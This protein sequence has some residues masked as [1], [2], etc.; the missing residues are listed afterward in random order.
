MAIEPHNARARAW[1][2]A[3]KKY[4]NLNEKLAQAKPQEVDA[5]ERAIAD[6][7]E[8]LLITS[9]P[10]LVALLKKIEILF[11]GQTHGLDEESE[12]KLLILEDLETLVRQQTE[13]L[14][15]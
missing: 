1:E 11:E 12:A 9:A 5:L 14:G 6:Q 15:A 8:D 13:L 4:L 2:T 7:Q 3:F 10:S